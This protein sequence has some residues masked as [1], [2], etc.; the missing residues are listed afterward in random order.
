MAIARV[1]T[2]K[3]YT[4]YWFYRNMRVA[5]D[6]AQEVKIRPLEENLYSLQFSCLGDWEVMEEGPWNFKEKAVVL[7]H[8]DG[9]TKSSMI[10]LDKIDIWLQIHDLPDGYFSK[11]K[12]MSATVGEFIFAESKS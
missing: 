5:W 7:A 6:L 1:H 10:E 12:A 9:F 2:D 3:T 8:Y 4:Q 11:I